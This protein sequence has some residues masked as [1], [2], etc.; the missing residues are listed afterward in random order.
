MKNKISR[1]I[2]RFVIMALG[3]LTLSIVLFIFT[4]IFIKGRS[5]ISLS[6]L[7]DEPKGM[8]IG[9]EG[10]IYPA[11]MGSFYLAILSGIIG[12]GIGI[13]VG[14]YLAFYPGN[15][16]V[17]LALR[18][19]ILSLAGIPSIIY[20]LVGYTLLIYK[21][22]FSRS[23]LCSSLTISAMI[24][25]FVAIRAD[26]I[27]KEKG[28]EYVRASEALGISKEYAIRKIVFPHCIMELIGT[29]ILGM[30][31]GMGA[32]APIMYTGAVMRAAVPKKLSDPFM[33]LP[34]HLYILVNNGISMES[35]YGTAFVL[36][37]LLLFIQ[38]VIKNIGRIR[39]RKL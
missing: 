11:I 29:L 13:L 9:T 8:P 20:G 31:F 16:W 23:L 32:T 4:Y 15:K 25:P 24:L 35:A 34:Y 12:G 19:S 39:R 14:L 33:S 37:G 1:N 21:F 26:K 10:G 3:I 27:F 7:L 18:G 6:F 17:H 5:R 30:A 2:L 22:G 38:I 28:Y 36:M